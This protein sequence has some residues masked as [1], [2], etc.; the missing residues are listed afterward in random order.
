LNSSLVKLNQSEEYKV[1]QTLHNYFKDLDDYLINGKSPDTKYNIPPELHA[2]KLRENIASDR[3]YNPKSTEK[4]HVPGIDYLAKHKSRN[5]K[6][7][8]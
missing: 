2:T 5:Q 4:P 3:V 1:N 8:S 7:A 6:K